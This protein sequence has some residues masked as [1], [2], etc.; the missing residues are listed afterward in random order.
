MINVY[1]I[2]VNSSKISATRKIVHFLNEEKLDYQVYTLWTKYYKNHFG[3]KE[4]IVKRFTDEQINEI[5]D[6]CV[7]YSELLMRTTSLSKSRNIDREQLVK[8]LS[9][10]NSQLRFPITVD[11]VKHI[12]LIGFREDTVRTLIP[13]DKRKKEMDKILFILEQQDQSKL[14]QSL[15]K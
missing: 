6:Y 15:M 12:S 10:I 5:L 7:D 13:K 11:T 1:L 4:K 9:S 2:P 8:E 3:S 14:N